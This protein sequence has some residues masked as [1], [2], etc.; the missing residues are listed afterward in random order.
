MRGTPCM[1]LDYRT[2]LISGVLQR[3]VLRAILFNIYLNDLFFFLL[4]I[5]ICNFANDAVPVDCDETLES[6][7]DKLYGNL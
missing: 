1:P 7:P 4:D 5:N 6:V 3:P 2:V